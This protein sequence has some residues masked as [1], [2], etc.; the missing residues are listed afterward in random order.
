M[1]ALFR[2]L[3][4]RANT[5]ARPRHLAGTEYRSSSYVPLGP[6]QVRGRRFSTARRGLHPEEVATFLD[7]V[8]NDLARVYAELARSQEENRRVKD[9]LRQ[10]QSRQ[11]PSMFELARR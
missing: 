10:W 6:W 2:R 7:R 11:A 1:R 4:G 3:T 5:P 8:A 9:A